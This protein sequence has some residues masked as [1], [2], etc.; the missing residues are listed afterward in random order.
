MEEV[1][2]RIAATQCLHLQVKEVRKFKITA[3][4]RQADYI[5]KRGAVKFF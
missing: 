5:L 1:Y 4:K 3:R 2:R